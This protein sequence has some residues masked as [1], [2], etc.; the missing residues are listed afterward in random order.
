MVEHRQ[1]DPVQHGPHGVV[2]AATSVI[3]I[4]YKDGVMIGTDT[5][6]N[7][8]GGMRVTDDFTRI[9]AI[10]DNILFS[11]S[12]E[13]ADYQKMKETLQNM[14]DADEMENDGA[15]FLKPRDYFNYIGASNY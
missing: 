9:A 10:S 13:M 14:Q 15:N 8:G 4:K 5:A 6:L 11:A 7:Y 1:R 3:A 2:N 12:G